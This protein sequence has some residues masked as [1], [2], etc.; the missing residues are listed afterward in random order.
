[1]KIDL[2]RYLH[3]RSTRHVQLVTVFAAK[4][5][6]S[7][8]S[9]KRLLAPSNLHS[10]LLGHTHKAINSL[11][12]DLKP[13]NFYFADCLAVIVGLVVGMKI[14]AVPPSLS[15]TLSCMPSGVHSSISVHG[16]CWA[17][18]LWGHTQSD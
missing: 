5:H 4:L 12:G 1:M 18:A 8:N 17:S 13:L 7:M 9:P 2:S 14:P 15:F 3:D 10:K 16:E 6:V 11:K